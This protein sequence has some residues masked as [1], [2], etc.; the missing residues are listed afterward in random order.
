MIRHALTECL[1]HKV[2][3]ATLKKTRKPLQVEERQYQCGSIPT[4]HSLKSP[5]GI[6]Q[7]AALGAHWTLRN[8][9]RTGGVPTLDALLTIW[10]KFT[11][12]LLGWGP[13]SEFSYVFQIFHDRL[14]DFKN[15]GVVT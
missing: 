14:V 7:W 15:Q 10:I 13:L 6:A 11:S 2:I 9:Y 8:T 5:R 3:F 1:F 12:L 4:I